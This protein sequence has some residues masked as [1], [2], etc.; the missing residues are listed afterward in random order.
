LLAD[1]DSSDANLRRNALFAL[2][3]NKEPIPNRYI[4]QLAADRDPKMRALSI[5][6]G[7]EKRRSDFS[8]LKPTFAKLMYDP[9]FDVRLAATK[10]FAAQGDPICA[11]PLLGLLKEV[12]RTGN[13]E[14]FTLA[15]SADAVAH[16]K[17]GFDS[18]T[19]RVPLQNERNEAALKRYAN[20]AR[21]REH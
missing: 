20:W 15:M 8:L 7:F 6:L 12:Y 2:T 3:D 13:G 5:G 9:E 14:F 18:G 11:S 21:L 10:N 17:F 16:Q 4:L 19:E 1:L